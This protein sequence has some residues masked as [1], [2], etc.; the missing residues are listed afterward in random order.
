MWEPTEYAKLVWYLTQSWPVTRPRLDLG[1]ACRHYGVEICPVRGSP[2]WSGALTYDAES[3]QWC[4]IVNLTSHRTL[5]RYRWTI[6]H[7]LGHRLMHAE[8]IKAGLPERPVEA[9]EADAFAAI[10]LM[11]PKA[12]RTDVGAWLAA[13]VEAP[14]L[15]Q[16]VAARYGVSRVAAALRLAE[17]GLVAA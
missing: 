3:G 10:A 6:A 2:G 9:R 8:R 12:L 11:P 15:P 7:E 4:I 14:R 1:R 17:L 13:R 16:L 5:G